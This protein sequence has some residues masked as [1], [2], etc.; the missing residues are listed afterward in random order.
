MVMLAIGRPMHRTDA[1]HSQRCL[2]HQAPLDLILH[3]CPH[4]L[5]LPPTHP[6]PPMGSSCVGGAGEGAR[7]ARRG[8]PRHAQQGRR[9]DLARHQEGRWD[10][11]TWC[12]RRCTRCV[13]FSHTSCAPSALLGCST[14]PAA[15]ARAP[16]GRGGPTE[17]S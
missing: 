14:I 17:R 10:G 5:F 1:V 2:T 9:P 3:R 4:H 12:G 6:S 16:G 11:T 13:P 15:G 8:A 7:G